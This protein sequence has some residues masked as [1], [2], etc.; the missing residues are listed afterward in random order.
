MTTLTPNRIL[1]KGDEYRDNG[2]DSK[3]VQWKPV[4]KDDFGLQVMF[5]KYAEVRR[6][7]ETPFVHG[8]A[9]AIKVSPDRDL[10]STPKEAVPAKAESDTKSPVASH[11]ATGDASYL[12]TVVSTKAHKNPAQETTSRNLAKVTAL[13]ETPETS[14]DASTEVAKPPV[15]PTPFHTPKTLVP[16]TVTITYPDNGPD[17]IWT[18]RNG[19]FKCRAVRL[20]NF[21]D[22]IRIVPVGKRGAARNAVIEFPS[23][24][25]EQVRLALNAMTP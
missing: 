9:P 16:A 14:K 25:I 20:E 10:A 22:V 12:P 8:G 21:G 6:P 13:R 11:S 3:N 2:H 17:C 24:C 23:S 7:S 4:P 15:S 18:G 19:T 5:T 1:Q